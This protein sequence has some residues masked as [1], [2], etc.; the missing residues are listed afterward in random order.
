LAVHYNQ[1]LVAESFL[2]TT[3]THS[4]RLIPMVLQLL[5][6]AEIDFGELQAVAVAAGPGSFTGLRIGMATAKGIAQVRD[7]PI[8][9]VNTLD[10]LAQSGLGFSGLIAPVLDARKNE[11]YTSLYKDQGGEITSVGQYRAITP[12]SLAD[13]LAS[14]TEKIMFVGDAVPAYRELWRERLS[15]QAIFLPDELSLPRGAHVG[16]LAAQRLA[17]GEQDDLYGL[18]PFYI[19]LSEAE[20]T[21]AKKFGQGV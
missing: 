2:H 14:R 3:K 15:G 20:V 10:A 1:E 4:E 16:A 18:T 8:V 5:E 7:I 21:W 11:V 17:R 9:G 12:A 6:N 13:E 19:R